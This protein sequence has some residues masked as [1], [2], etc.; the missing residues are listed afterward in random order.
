LEDAQVVS[1]LVRRCVSGDAAAWE[2]IVQR[3]HRRI[4]NICYRFAGTG[5]DAQDLTQEVFIKMYRTL[6]SYDVDRGAFMTWVT[7]MTRNLLVDHFRKTKQDRVTDSLDGATSEHE[8]AT[9]LSEQIQDKG[10][11]PDAR[12]ESRE[13]SETVHR[14]LE[15]LSPELRE[16][17]ILRDLQDMDYREIAAVLKVPEGTVKSRINR[18]RAELARL[19]QRTYKQV[20]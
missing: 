14:A 12:V 17:V 5:D 1:L 18:G 3:Y 9:P 20:I 16:A 19:L 4:Y 15:K 6:S 8:D 13:T 10:L 11:P 2:E 7:T